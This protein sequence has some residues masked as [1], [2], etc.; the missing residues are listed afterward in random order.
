MTW[1][2]RHTVSRRSTRTARNGIKPPE[3]RTESRPTAARPRRSEREIAVRSPAR[4]CQD[5]SGR[6]PT[7]RGHACRGRRA[8]ATRRHPKLVG[9]IA[10]VRPGTPARGR[11]GLSKRR[12][13][14]R[15]PAGGNSSLGDSVTQKLGQ[16]F[17][18]CFRLE[19]ADREGRQKA[20]RPRVLPA[21][22]EPPHREMAREESLAS[23]RKVG[24]HGQGISKPGR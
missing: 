16:S 2:I 11:S 7:G 19:R 17:P 14:G 1:I 3:G 24:G 5:T 18:S 4:R 21:K 9:S 13:A 10:V 8:A 22:P 12:R 20:K 15:R 23:T 6:S